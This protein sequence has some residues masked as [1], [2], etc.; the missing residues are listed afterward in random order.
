MSGVR[1]PEIDLSSLDERHIGVLRTLVR[2]E[3]RRNAKKIAGLAE[4]F[5]D[6]ANLTHLTEKHDML[7]DIY[8]ALGSDPAEITNVRA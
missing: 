3:V 8:R 2:M 1:M 7:A 5:G 6:E 4:R